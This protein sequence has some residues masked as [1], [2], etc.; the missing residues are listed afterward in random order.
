MGIKNIISVRKNLF[1]A[2]SLEEIMGFDGEEEGVYMSREC[3]SIFIRSYSKKLGMTNKY[4]EKKQSFRESI[5]LQV[6]LFAKAIVNK[7]PDIYEPF[8]IR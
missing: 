2:A 5:N 8:T 3:R 4:L 1:Q 6:E 7:D